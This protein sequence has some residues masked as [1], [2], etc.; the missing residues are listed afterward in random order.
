MRIKP[1]DL[2]IFF[3]HSSEHEFFLA[4]LFFS[5][6]TVKTEKLWRKFINCN[7]YKDHINFPEHLT[8]GFG[9]FPF[10]FVKLM[11]VLYGTFQNKI[12]WGKLSN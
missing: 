10:G 4:F 11:W 8:P 12:M 2:G 7:D 1:E 5:P 6:I 3:E 9:G